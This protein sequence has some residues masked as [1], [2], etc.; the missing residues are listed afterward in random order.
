MIPGGANPNPTPAPARAKAK[1]KAKAKAKAAAGANGVDQVT[2]KTNDEIK[3]EISR[4][5][6]FFD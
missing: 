5:L 1:S 4:G 6:C 3:A 2:P